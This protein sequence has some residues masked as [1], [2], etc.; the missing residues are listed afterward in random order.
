MVTPR[1]RNPSTSPTLPPTPAKLVSSIK[2]LRELLDHVTQLDINV[3]SS[4][5]AVDWG[6]LII[7]VILAFRLSF[8]LPE[9]QQF[10][11]V[12]ARNELRLGEFLGYMCAETDLTPS[13]SKVDVLSAS[14]VVFRVVKDKFN[15]R[16]QLAKAA[17]VNSIRLPRS[18]GCP[19]LDGSLD[20]FFPIWDAGLTGGMAPFAVG[21]GSQ[22]AAV[23]AR[24]VFHD[25]WAT[26]TMGWADESPGGYSS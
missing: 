6:R 15:K 22:A 3:F 14:R 21:G 13:A 5:T 20:E 26:M 2:P 1:P 25:L 18:V 24:P 23:T 7:A 4:F 11:H 17:E 19:M 10:D 12:H 16:L 8:R 9:C